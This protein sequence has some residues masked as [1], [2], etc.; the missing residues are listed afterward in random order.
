M[1]T[2]L[3]V[4]L[5]V[6]VAVGCDHQGSRPLVAIREGLL[7]GVVGR[8]SAGR[9]FYSFKGIPYA[10]PPLGALRFQPPQ[11]HGVWSGVVDAMEHGSICYQLNLLKNKTRDGSEDCLFANVY[12]PQLP[13]AEGAAGGLP[14]M[15][16]IHSGGFFFGDGN[17]DFFGPQFL[18]DGG[19]VLVTFNYRLGPFGFFTTHDINAPGNYGLLDQVMLLQW[20][21]DNIAS[22][23]GDPKAV[24]IFG[25]SAGG[26]SVSLLVLSPLAKGLFQHAITQSGPSMAS[27]VAS[28]RRY[29]LA[30]KLANLVNCTT[31]DVSSMVD[32][33]RG[34]PAYDL[35]GAILILDAEQERYFQPRVDRESESPF[36]PDDPRTILETGNFNLVPW[37]N[38]VM[39]EEGTIFLPD[40]LRTISPDGLFAGNITLWGLLSDLNTKAESP[41]LDCGADALEQATKVYNFY[42]GNATVNSDNLLPLVRV[43]TDRFYTA[44]F[45][46]EIRLA[47]EHAPVYKYLLDHTGPGRQ[48]L[49]SI[50]APGA[51]DFGPTHGDDLLYL[52]SG[53]E[54]SPTV[55]GSPDDRMIRF[56]VSVWTSFARTGRPSS[57]VL[58]M[59]DWPIFTSQS[60]RHMRLNS[61][62]SVGERLF[63]ERVR[64][65]QGVPINEPWRH[66]VRSE[67]PPSAPADGAEASPAA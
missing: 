57:D 58:P 26:S 22:F 38:G 33:V 5:L 44:P 62:P 9:T 31:D 43:V 21:Q 45:S 19:V 56:M 18:M 32:C 40:V 54:R 14:V 41:I 23:G 51:P 53:D 20:V 10:R 37:M 39:E 11:R 7:R 35:L 66:A 64:F 4:T 52:F 63:E 27:Y 15:V 29:G 3:S 2:L 60:Q 34:V 61:E 25:E 24:T 47:S 16:F 28:G 49:A 48:S 1:Q 6:V 42:V 17:S 30:E 50:F 46:E 59:P 55:P 65:W 67:C 8:S 13:S 12:T 36:L